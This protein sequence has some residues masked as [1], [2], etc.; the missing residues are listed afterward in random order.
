MRAFS[1]QDTLIPWIVKQYINSETSQVLE[2]RDKNCLSKT[3]ILLFKVLLV[4]TVYCECCLASI[5]CQA[6]NF[7]PSSQKSGSLLDS[8]D[9]RSGKTMPLNTINKGM[10]GTVMLDSSNTRA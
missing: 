4:L 5:K 8:I 3:R 2:T 7:I 9:W 10:K 1:Q 6:F